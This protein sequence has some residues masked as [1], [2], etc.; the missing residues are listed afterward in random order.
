[1][2]AALR[3]VDRYFEEAVCGGLLVVLMCLLFLQVI[4]RYVFSMSWS[5]N[6]EVT[7]FV[8]VWF[9]YLGACLGVQRQG[10]IRV[11]TFVTMLPQGLMRKAVLLLADLIWLAFLIIVFYYSLD[12]LDT[13]LQFP[14]GSAVLDIPLFYVY[15]IIPGGFML[16]MLRLVQ[17]YIQSWCAIDPDHA[18]EAQT[19][20]DGETAS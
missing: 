6:E 3:L 8:F 15:L 17:L 4:L 10:H 11:M 18:G 16:M 1:M 12:F 2:R 19:G 14:Q 7:R 9:I 5:W 13:V 20:N